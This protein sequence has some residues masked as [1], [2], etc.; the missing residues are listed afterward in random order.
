MV[1]RK[2]D[3]VDGLCEVSNGTKRWFPGEVAEI[4]ADGCVDIK[5]TSSRIYC[6]IIDSYNIINILQFSDGEYGFRKS[7]EQVRLRRR[8]ASALV[9]KAGNHSRS[10]SP[11]IP[12]D[13][14]SPTQL[15]TV[16]QQMASISSFGGSEVESG[17][18]S[19]SQCN[20]L[21]LS[22]YNY[23]ISG[24]GGERQRLLHPFGPRSS[25]QIL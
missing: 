5:V 13:L 4:H 3:A 24:L 15:S 25:D 23:N 8:K 19:G 17:Y 9:P 14:T 21:L 18:N 1:F 2:G 11:C 12:L 20:Y 16:G 6:L 10:E 7:P 22:P